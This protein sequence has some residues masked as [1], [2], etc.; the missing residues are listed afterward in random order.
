MI[1]VSLTALYGIKIPTISSLGFA[2]SHGWVLYVMTD[3]VLPAFAF[4]IR[5]NIYCRTL[6]VDPIQSKILIPI[7]KDLQVDLW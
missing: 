3:Q 2:M 7:V 5:Y 1:S 4:A 6:V